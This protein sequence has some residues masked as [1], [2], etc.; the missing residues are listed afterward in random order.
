MQKEVYKNIEIISSKENEIIL[1]IT[2][3]GL[4]MILFSQ[5]LPPNAQIKLFIND[6]FVAF[7]QYTNGQHSIGSS[8]NY[9]KKLNENDTIKFT[10]IHTLKYNETN[11]SVVKLY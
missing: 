1:K 9:L 6:E 11:I 5:Y 8:I 2:K 3:K 10:S 4:Y 7:G